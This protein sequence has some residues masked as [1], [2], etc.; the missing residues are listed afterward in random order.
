MTGVHKGLIPDYILGGRSSGGFEWFVLELKGVNHTLF[1]ESK[2]LLYLSS[3][4]NKAVCQTIEYIDYCSSIQSHLRDSFKLTDFRGPKGLILL[5]REDEFSKS[6]R[7]EALKAAWNRFMGNK[8][9]IRTYDSM[10]RHVRSEVS[11]NKDN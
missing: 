11:L 2:K 7:R 9:E 10:L 3:T 1:I 6:K 5:G 4:A 8:I